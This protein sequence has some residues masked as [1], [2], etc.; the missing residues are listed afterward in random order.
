MDLFVS[1]ALI[2]K[3]RGIKGEVVADLL[4]DF[5]KRFASVRSVRILRGDQTFE[6]TLERYWFH[7]GRVILRFQGRET[8][9]TAAPLVGGYVQVPEEERFVPPRNT[10]YHSDLIGCQIEEKGQILGVVTGI[11]ES[12]PENA[13]LV[14]RATDGNEVMIPL[15]KQFVKKVDIGGKRIRIKSLPGLF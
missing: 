5:P 3:T 11:F 4:T 1:V 7:R 6:E 2:I 13:N 14:V 12:G 8:P 10:Y 9:E 15:V